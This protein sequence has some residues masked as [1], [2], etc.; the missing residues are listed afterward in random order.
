MSPAPA[1]SSQEDFWDDLLSSIERRRVIPIVGAELLILEKDGVSTPLYRAVAERLLAKYGLSAEQ[2]A[3]RDMPLRKH[4]ELND[5]VCALSA[6]GCRVRDLYRPTHDILKSLLSEFR[7]PPTVLRELAHISHFNFFLTTTPDD[8]LAR[9]LNDVRFQGKAQTVEI[10]YAPKLP[11]ERSTRD[12][13]ASLNP[14]YTAVFYLFGKADVAPFYAIHDEDALE[15]PYDLQAKGVPERVLS[16]L[17]SRDLLLVGCTFADWLSRFFLRLSNTERLFSDHRMKKEFLV[18]EETPG[19]RDFTVFLDRFSQDTRYE[20]TEARSF[21]SEMHRRWLERNPSVS[22][23]TADKRFE[24]GSP[25]AIFLS[26]AREDIKPALRLYEE[27]KA[28]SD[29]DVTWFDKS[30]VMPGDVW[31]P[32]TLNAIR[33]CKLFLP[34]LSVNTERRNEGYFRREWMEA[35]ERAKSIHGK[36]I[37]PVVVDEDYDGDARRYAMVPEPFQELHYGH[38]PGGRVSAEL[39]A[40]VQKQLRTV[41]KA[42][43][44]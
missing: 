10:E 37:L 23:A 6:V 29:D 28:L 41:R 18:G 9:A 39:K 42:Q 27:L 2:I 17:R 15:F 30:E 1:Q 5:A 7:E 31:G 19:D 24:I 44:L 43:V 11:T 34:L 14:D 8:L 32:H 33:T 20:R 35:L 3:Y 26:Y 40:E 36:F 25:H 22:Q 13:P 12:I 38:A 21:I 16:Q 4:H